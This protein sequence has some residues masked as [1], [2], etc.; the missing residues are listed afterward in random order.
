MQIFG[1]WWVW[2]FFFIFWHTH[3]ERE[4]SGSNDAMKIRKYD[5]W[6]DVW[7]VSR[8]HGAKISKN[9][10]FFCPES[11]FN[12]LGQKIMLL[13]RHFRT[14]IYIYYSWVIRSKLSSLERADS[15]L[16]SAENQTSISITIFRPEPI[17]VGS[18]PIS[19]NDK[20]LSRVAHAIIESC[21]VTNWSIFFLRYA[22]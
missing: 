17:E 5:N 20:G 4:N 14:N 6:E 18:L 9:V 19:S 8:Y 21:D 11:I 16:Y 12:I 10:L 22:V 7:W 2:I 13:V 15:F 3:F 1:F